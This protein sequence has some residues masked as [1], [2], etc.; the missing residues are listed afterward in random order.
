MSAR[1]FLNRHPVLTV[2]LVLVLTALAVTSIVYQLRPE[3][4]ISQIP[5]RDYYTVDDGE[6]WFVD[7]VNKA[8]PFDHGGKPAVGARLFTC[9]GGKTRFVGYLEKLPDGAVDAYRSRMHVSAA[10]VPEADEVAAVIGSLVKRKGDAQ[11][12]PSSD[13]ERFAEIE[14]V[15]CPDGK[16]EPEPVRPATG[17]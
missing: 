2:V 5:L 10:D 7:E 14:R 6:T 11:W 12:V 15:R 17:E 16:G 9:D 4:E 8:T 13:A 3:S 1:V